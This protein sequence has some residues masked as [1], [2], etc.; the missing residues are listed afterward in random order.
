DHRIGEQFFAGGFERCFGFGAISRGKLD[1]EYFSLAHALDAFNAERLQRALDR[2]AL[3]IEYAG[4]E[5]DRNARFHRVLAR[6]FD[7]RAPMR[8]RLNCVQPLTR[9]GPVPCTG[10]FS[11]ITPSRRATSV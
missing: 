7:A 1:I 9:I 2:L 11:A 3:R 6:N 10:S 8:A 5:R 4:F